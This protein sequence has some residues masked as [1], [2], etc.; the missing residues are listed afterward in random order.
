MQKPRLAELTT[1]QLE[2][3]FDFRWFDSYVVFHR[4]DGYSA[5]LNTPFSGV[6]CTGFAAIVKRHGAQ[7][8]GLLTEELDVRIVSYHQ[9]DNPTA[10]STLDCNGHDFALMTNRWLVDGW[11][12]DIAGLSPRAVFDLQDPADAAVIAKWYGD[13]RKWYHNKKVEQ[14]CFEIECWA[15]HRR[16]FVKEQPLQHA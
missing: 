8:L 1:A 9:Q 4:E 12:R 14:H 5:F 15:D 13:R 2:Q 7:H 10:E 6:Q 3:A 11:I 16:N